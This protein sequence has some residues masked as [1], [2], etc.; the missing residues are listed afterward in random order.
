[1]QEVRRGVHIG[2][3][4][5]F[6]GS[7]EREIPREMFSSTLIVLLIVVT[8][9]GWVQFEAWRVLRNYEL[10]ARRINGHVESEAR[11]WRRLLSVIFLPGVRV[12][13]DCNGIEVEA[14]VV[15]AYHES[16]Y[17]EMNA[18]P[19]WDLAPLRLVKKIGRFAWSIMEYPVQQIE[20]EGFVVTGHVKLANSRNITVG[21]ATYCLD[22]IDPE[23]AT[24]LVHRANVRASLEVLLAHFNAI[25]IGQRNI[26]LIK[27][28]TWRD[29]RA[30]HILG[31]FERLAR[32]TQDMRV[33]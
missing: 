33:G 5:I 1:M 15:R 27:R 24:E 9:I 22:A 26:R 16:W 17:L 12:I 20:R 28:W 14:V 2:V 10:V 13:G 6:L 32:L 3:G 31:L 19:L 25:E 30:T 29:G 8:G 21:A 7:R 4:A 11:G 18:R 23:V